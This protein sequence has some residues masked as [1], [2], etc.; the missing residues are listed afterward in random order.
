MDK[1]GSLKVTGCCH[2]SQA[3]MDRSAVEKLM[4][5]IA[6][7]NSGFAHARTM[8][9]MKTSSGNDQVTITYEITP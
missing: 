2:S 5:L 1:P 7:I 4:N 8:S 6:L 9:D 3:D